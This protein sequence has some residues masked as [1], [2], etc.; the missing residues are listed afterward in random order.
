VS[1]RRQL[2]VSHRSFAFAAAVVC[3]CLFG[4]SAQRNV[5]SY[6]TT[7][8]GALS[9]ASVVFVI[10]DLDTPFEGIFAVSSQPMRDA[11]AELSQ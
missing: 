7:V 8:L 5:L 11:L 9:I 3:H 6:L 10:L 4:L 1:Q 2:F